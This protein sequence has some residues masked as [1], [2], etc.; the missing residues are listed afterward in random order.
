MKP[1]SLLAIQPPIHRP[2]HDL[3]D[4]LATQPC[5][6]TSH[7]RHRIHN[8]SQ[9]IVARNLRQLIV[10]L[11]QVPLRSLVP[12][13][14]EELHA[15]LPRRSVDLIELLRRRD[16]RALNVV[17]GFAVGDADDVD[18]F[19]GVGIGLDAAEV[20][21]ENLVEA[22]ASGRAAAGSDG[23]ED[24]A[25]DGGLRDVVVEGGVWVVEEED[26]DAVGV[27]RGADWCDGFECFGG[28]VPATSD[29]GAAVVDEE[30]RVETAEKGIGVVGDLCDC[31]AWDL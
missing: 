15:H 21:F 23:L 25:H 24:L 11:L 9:L 3:Q 10:Q 7:K 28:L 16:E 2:K 5:A 12:T 17:G 4:P 26:V 19:R 13:D 6:L 29:H 1:L 27:V 20:G 8:V 18:R 14:L 22:L 30:D 31:Y